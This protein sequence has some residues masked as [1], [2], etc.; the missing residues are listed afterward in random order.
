M[1]VAYVCT[2]PG[3]P[4]FGSK[5]ASVHVQAVLPRGSDDL[6]RQGQAGRDAALHAC[7]RRIRERLGVS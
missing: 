5:G 3:V 4:V 6:D 2:D 1:R 7:D